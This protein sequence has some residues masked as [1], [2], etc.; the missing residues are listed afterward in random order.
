M[1]LQYQ[2]FRELSLGERSFLEDTVGISLFEQHEMLSQELEALLDIYADL[3]NIND[4]QPAL[5]SMPQ[6]TRDKALLCTQILQMISELKAQGISTRT[7]RDVV[8][9]CIANQN[10]DGPEDSDVGEM[11]P[12]SVSI[13]ETIHRKLYGFRDG[14]PKLGEYRGRVDEIPDELVRKITEN[15]NTENQL[16]RDEIQLIQYSLSDP[17]SVSRGS[18]ENYRVLSIDDLKLQIK[19]LERLFKTPQA[20]GAVLKASPPTK[21]AALKPS[22]PS[23]KPS[24]PSKGSARRT[25]PRAQF[26]QQN[27]SPISSTVSTPNIVQGISNPGS[28][29][30]RFQTLQQ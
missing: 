22:P 15:I 8:R 5:P 30:Y 3:Q 4:A 9:F 2:I 20:T 16:L 23:I 10:L 21:I 24:P 12:T 6:N 29:R 7:G 25:T 19:R 27:V 26:S 18:I 1:K 14:Y 17:R 28:S 13:K 11:L